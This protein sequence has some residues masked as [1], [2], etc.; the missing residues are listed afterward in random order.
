M[1]YPTRPSFTTPG[2][3]VAVAYGIE[4]GSAEN[5]EANKFIKLDALL[6]KVAE[7]VKELWKTFAA[8]SN[9]QRNWDK[10]PLG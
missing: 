9:M 7:D 2:D 1:F 6:G 4:T 5:F 3:S 8:F 10:G